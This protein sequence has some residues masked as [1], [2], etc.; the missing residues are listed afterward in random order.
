[1]KSVSLGA[2]FA[3]ADPS[4]LMSLPGDGPS[5]LIDISPAGSGSWDWRTPGRFARPTAVGSVGRGTTAAAAAT[6]RHR[7]RGRPIDGRQP[8]KRDIPC[9]RCKAVR[10]GEKCQQADEGRTGPWHHSPLAERRTAHQ[11][12]GVYRLGWHP[13]RALPLRADRATSGVR[14]LFAASC[15]ASV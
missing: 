5:S 3:A 2:G 12:G 8:L 7:P 4:R 14:D 1:M 13:S 10:R 15:M 9:R 11:G 6:T